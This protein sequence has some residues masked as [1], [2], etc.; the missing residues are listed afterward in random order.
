[1]VSEE[2]QP[3][4]LRAKTFIGDLTVGSHQDVTPWPPFI[5]LVAELSSHPVSGGTIRLPGCAI[6]NLAGAAP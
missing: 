1:M 3:C 4:L 6:V 2:N 5:L